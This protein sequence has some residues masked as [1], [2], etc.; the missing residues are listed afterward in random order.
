MAETPALRAVLLAAGFAT[1]LWP[2]TRDRAKPLLEVGGEP[3]LTRLLRQVEAT[4]VV[5]EALVATNARFHAD[6]ERWRDPLDTS[7][8]VALVNDGATEDA[9]RL[10]AVADLDLALGRSPWRDPVDGWLV[11]AG[12]N[13]IDFPLRPYVDRFLAGGAGQLIVR[14]LDTPPPPRKYNEV[15]ADERGRV[16]SFREKPE[17]SASRLAAIAVYVLPP[18]LPE[19]VAAHLAGGGMRDAPGHLIEQLVQRIPFEA[20][21]IAGPWFDIGDRGDLEAARAAVDRG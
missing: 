1:R 3:M 2:L 4:G 8:E 10:G 6:F 5:R 18:E 13:L 16:T 9:N 21:P 14:E 19:L 15:I 7:I 17:R 11:L 12:D 20:S